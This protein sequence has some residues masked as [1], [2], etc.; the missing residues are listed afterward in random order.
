[1]QPNDAL[2]ATLAA[3]RARDAQGDL[4][5]AAAALDAAP[6]AQQ[7][8]G[9]WLYARGAVAFRL[10][11]LPRALGYFEAAVGREPKVA[12]YRANLGAV[13][14][15]QAKRGDEG[16]LERA[17]RELEE[18]L[19]WGGTQ[20]SVRNNLGMA[21][22]LSKEPSRALSCFEAALAVDGAHV[23][24]LYNR[25]A[26]LAAMGRDEDALTALDLVLK[27]APDFEPALKS[28]D[29]TLARLGRKG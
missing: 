10:G 2:D 21:W 29:N 22:L 19:R 28:R 23:P 24:S 7:Q 26:A 3:A 13:L 5:G 18:A 11:E 27:V 17:R 6:E 14:L 16:A 4:T 9:A 20:P 12:E 1:M 15:E 25:A 8:T